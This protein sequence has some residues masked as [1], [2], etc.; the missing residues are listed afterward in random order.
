MRAVGINLTD[1][2]DGALCEIQNI[3][4]PMDKGSLTSSNAIY[5][6]EEREMMNIV[7]TLHP[8]ENYGHLWYG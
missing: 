8:V 1:V 6:E 4:Q 2:A 5:T 3:M 7:D